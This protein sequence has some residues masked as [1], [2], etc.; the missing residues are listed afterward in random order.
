MLRVSITFALIVAATLF[1]QAIA[2]SA[3]DKS[4]TIPLDKIWA[5][6][7]PGTRDIRD[8][9]VAQKEQQGLSLLNSIGVSSFRR[10]ERMGFKEIA[11]PGFVVSGSGRSALRA[12]S[13]VF[14]DGVKPRER[15][16]PDD[17]ITIVFFSEPFSKYRVRIKQVKQTAKEVEFLYQLEPSIEGRNFTNFALIPLG[18]LPAGTYRVEMRQSPHELTP[19]EKMYR[20]K[21]LDEEWSRNFLCKPFCFTVAGTRK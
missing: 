16:S 13:A 19:V 20:F 4:Q 17:E 11:R 8:L 6:E 18:K 21:S 12:A 9:D 7:M 2:E 5:Y 15:F 10:A 3:D 14:I 1:G